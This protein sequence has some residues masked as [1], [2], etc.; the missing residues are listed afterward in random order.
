VFFD[1]KLL[2]LR[3]PRPCGEFYFEHEAREAAH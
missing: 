3:P 1:Q 2:I